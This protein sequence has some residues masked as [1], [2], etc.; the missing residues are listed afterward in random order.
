MLVVWLCLQHSPA[1]AAP[2]S[3]DGPLSHPCFI[4]GS[5]GANPQ[6]L[7]H[8]DP[9][10]DCKL[11]AH[12]AEADTVWVRF[13]L[14]RDAVEGSTGWTY[15][16]ALIQ[17]K[18]ERVWIAYAD[19]RFRETLTKRDDA[20]AVLGGRTQRYAFAKEPGQIVALLVRMDGLENRRGPVPRASMTSA[21]RGGENMAR[22]YLAFG[23]MAGIMFGILFYNVSLFFALRY[24][25]LAAYCGSIASSVLYGIVDSNMILWF[26]PGMTTD[27]QFGWN[28]FSISLC[29]LMTSLYFW[30]FIEDGKVPRWLLRA[31]SGV[32][33]VVT[34]FCVTRI[35]GAFLPWRVGDAILYISFVTMIILFTV[36]SVI[37]WRR[38][39]SAV[40]FYLLAWTAPVAIAFIRIL[41]GIG[42]VQVENAIFDAT[43]L[44]A[45]CLEALMGSISLSWRLGQ[46]RSERDSAKDQADE[47]YT[48]ANMDSLT[49][50]ANRRCFHGRAM[51]EGARHDVV[52]L[53]LIDVDKFKAVN[54]GFGHD[55]GDLVLQR[56]AK[57][58]VASGADVI[59]RL[60]GDEFAIV[61]PH[62]DG[63][64]M[65]HRVSEHLLMNMA[66]DDLGVTLSMGIATGPLKT[67]QDWQAL[68]IAADM[69]LYQ[70]KRGGRARWTEAPAYEVAIPNA[71]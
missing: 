2:A 58:V 49:A 14:S 17:A 12:S 47:L 40:K 45:L 16:H 26:A 51:W 68:Y 8:G 48:L 7:I 46:L 59:G 42:A 5:P 37:A 34:A 10:F 15:D 44:V 66:P 21:A 29:F 50:I 24:R 6:Q 60:G 4:L 35:F 23:L 63:A 54:D 22:Y 65:A 9:H 61:T 19:G 62:G 69:A 3:G 27:T 71:A 70:S 67:E 39:S 32:G 13:D 56:V 36:N 53:I 33:A 28:M 25:V 20:R 1:S 18:D 11:D 31:G 38:G 41:W 57:A 64:A 30:E 55:A 52:Q 43:T